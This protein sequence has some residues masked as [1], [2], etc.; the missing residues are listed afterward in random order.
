MRPPHFRQ[1]V[2]PCPDLILLDL[3]L[4]DLTGTQVCRRLRAEP[5]TRG[6]PVIIMSAGAAEIDR[7]VELAVGADDYV[8]KPFSIREL[9]SRIRAVLQRKNHSCN[10][11]I[12][13]PALRT[14]PRFPSA[15]SPASFELSLRADV[16]L[17]RS[18]TEARGDA[19]AEAGEDLAAG[20][21]GTRLG[22][23][24]AGPSRQ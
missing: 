7:V 17:T 11:A 12:R 15:A 1:R 4:P 3:L 18:L 10:P 14:R 6:V 22:S 16:D 24:N 8:L 23:V 21:I 9:L 5:E 2:M 19:Q 13:S 20:Q